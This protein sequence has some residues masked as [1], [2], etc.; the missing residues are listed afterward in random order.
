MNYRKYRQKSQERNILR[1]HKKYKKSDNT[2][3]PVLTP[4]FPIITSLITADREL[5]N[6]YIQKF[7]NYLDKLDYSKQEQK[8]H[9][10]LKLSYQF[11]KY[12]DINRNYLR[13]AYKRVIKEKYCGQ[14]AKP[15]YGFEIE[16]YK[17]ENMLSNELS[18]ETSLQSKPDLLSLKLKEVFFVPIR[19]RNIFCRFCAWS[20]SRRKLKAIR[21]LFEEDIKQKKLLSFVT[22]TFPN[23]KLEEVKSSIRSCNEALSRLYHF[24]LGKRNIKIL[25]IEAKKELGKYLANLYKKLKKKEK[26]SRLEIL[27]KVIKQ[28][29]FHLNLIN[30]FFERIEKFQNEFDSSKLKFGLLFEG[31]WKFELTYN[32]IDKTWNPHWHG[33]IRQPISRFVLLAIVKRLGFGDILDIRAVKGR[34]A[35]LE[36]SKYEVKEAVKGKNVNILQKIIINAVL[37]NFKK[38]RVWFDSQLRRKLEELSKEEEKNKDLTYVM[39]KEHKWHVNYLVKQ[40]RIPELYRNIRDKHPELFGKLNIA[41]ANFSFN[42][43]PMEFNVCLDN[44]GKFI[45]NPKDINKLELA[46]KVSGVFE[47]LKE[48]ILTKIDEIKERQYIYFDKSKEELN[49]KSFSE[50]DNIRAGP[51]TDEILSEIIDRALHIE[52]YFP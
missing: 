10:I 50:D 39:L 33:I 3:Y 1:E 22:L 24:R 23:F 11:E 9:L 21:Y 14:T 37:M 41:K 26:Y 31:V 6:T 27:A 32:E 12:W 29:E 8:A 28:K 43:K 5:F 48:I 38:L 13:R 25:K 52:H 30:E 7:S 15:W 46:L 2:I 47:E 36:L 17:D 40:E 4:E 16:T 49:Q 19:C 35:F 45:I 18:L 44:K 20:E 51:I 42:G 34:E